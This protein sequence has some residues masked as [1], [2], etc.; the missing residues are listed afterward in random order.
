M[1]INNEIEEQSLNLKKVKLKN[2]KRQIKK[3]LVFQVRDWPY[4]KKSIKDEYEK[5]EPRKDKDL[6]DLPF[7]IY[8][9]QEEHNKPKV[10]INLPIWLSYIF[11]NQD[12]IY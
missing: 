6:P 3:E 1:K 8:V 10:K 12:F 4:R 7:D 11:V 9:S 2:I 5:F